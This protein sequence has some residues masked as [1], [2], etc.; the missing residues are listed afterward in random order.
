MRGGFPSI[1]AGL[2]LLMSLSAILV[3]P[4][5]PIAENSD[6]SLSEEQV[7]TLEELPSS[8]K[9]IGR[10]SNSTTSP[11]EWAVI[12]G[13]SY[14]DSSIGIVVDSNGNA[15]VA[16]VFYNTANFGDIIHESSGDS[17]IFIAKLSS[18]GSWQWAVKAGG[19][20][21]DQVLGI[22]ADSNGSVYVSGDFKETATFGSNSLTA[23]A[24]SDLFIAKL[25]SSGSWQWVVRVGSDDD[26]VSGGPITAD[27]SGNVYVTGSSHGTAFG[28]TNISGGG[29]FI[30]KLS[31]SGSWQ[32][33]AWGDFVA[34]GIAVDSN[35]NTFVTGTFFNTANFGD[36]IL[37]SSGDSDIFIA[38]LSSSGSSI[39]VKLWP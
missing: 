35:G 31:S 3:V 25:S 17:D 5:E 28:S 36:I 1:A 30:A 38:K 15:F 10:D 13:G 19:S 24:Y 39:E 9:I 34:P 22:A 18:S 2:L 23:G 12:A 20:E 6:D 7:K 8:V 4:I 32:W 21:R 29:F 16:G 11:W 37:E 26:R 14:T 27:S 33:A